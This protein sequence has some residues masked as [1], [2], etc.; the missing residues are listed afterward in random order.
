MKTF[1]LLV[2]S[3]LTLRCAPPLPVDPAPPNQEFDLRFGESVRVGTGPTILIKFLRV[4]E[5][6]RCPEG[7]VCV[8]E[9][10]ARIELSLER[11][12]LIIPPTIAPLNTALDPRST[13]FAGYTITLRRLSPYPKYR[14]QID[15]RAYI[16]RLI[17]TK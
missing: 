11:E 8:W 16:A 3:F 13:V 5:D 14:T 12:R 4:N 10:N 9:G 15:P 1:I 6:S 2:A 17:V 7:V